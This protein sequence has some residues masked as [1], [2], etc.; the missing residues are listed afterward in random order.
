MSTGYHAEHVGSLLRPPWLLEARA[1]NKRGELSDAD[2]REAEDRAASEVIELQRGAGLRVFTDGEVRRTNWMEGLL[3]SIGGLVPVE[4]AGVDWRPISTSSPRT[5]G[6]S[7]GCST[8]A[9][10]P[11]SWPGKHRASSRSR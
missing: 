7:S 1:A 8:P 2:L 4:R 5:H 10:R 6:C 9:P 11:R 3:S